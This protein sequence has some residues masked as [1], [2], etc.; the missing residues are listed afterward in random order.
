MAL[1][2]WDKFSPTISDSLSRWVSV[3]APPPTAHAETAASDGGA[4]AR[5]VRS[6]PGPHQSPGWRDLR[7]RS[8]PGPPYPAAAAVRWLAAGAAACAPQPSAAPGRTTNPPRAA[9][10][11]DH[12]R[13]TGVDSHP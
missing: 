6:T 3:P 7:N 2:Q 10:G 9:R 8:A 11:D 1:S 13:E 5:P 12:P 4:L